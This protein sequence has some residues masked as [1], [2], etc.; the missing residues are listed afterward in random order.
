VDLTEQYA[1]GIQWDSLVGKLVNIGAA[2]PYAAP[3]HRR[4]CPDADQ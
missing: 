2:F 1:T 4:H 3:Y